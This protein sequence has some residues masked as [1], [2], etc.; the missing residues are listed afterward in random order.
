MLPLCD[1]NPKAT[2]KAEEIFRNSALT[3]KHT[4]R[5]TFLIAGN[6]SG[7]MVTDVLSVM[8]VLGIIEKLKERNG[9]S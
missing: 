8:Y 5:G 7:D 9:V 3:G 4:Q 6:L 1:L 2:R